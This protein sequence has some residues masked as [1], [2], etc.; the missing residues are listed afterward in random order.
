[1]DGRTGGWTD[2]RTQGRAD[3]RAVGRADNVN[4]YD[5]Y[6]SAPEKLR[7]QRIHHHSLPESSVGLDL[8]RRQHAN[9]IS[10]RSTRCQSVRHLC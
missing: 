7:L 1:M 3:G 9:E 5:C 6:D 8:S 2:E 10:E 4:T